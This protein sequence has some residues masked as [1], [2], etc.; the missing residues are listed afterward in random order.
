MKSAFFV[1]ACV[2]LP[3]LLVGCQPVK[4]VTDG[5]FVS[6]DSIELGLAVA[7]RTFGIGDAFDVTVRARNIS[8][9]P[10]TIRARS[11]APVYL[12]VNRFSAMGEDEFKTFPEAATMVMSAWTIQPGEERTFVLTL[13]VEADWPRNETLKLIAELNGYPGLMPFTTIRI[14]PQTSPAGSA[15]K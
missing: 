4:V 2:I 10:I 1:T 8:K 6:N 7:R 9:Q 13:T 11:G 14:L 3:L 5:S 15:G 12:H